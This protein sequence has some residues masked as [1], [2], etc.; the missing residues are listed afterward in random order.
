MI[1]TPFFADGID[2]PLVAL[3]GIAVLVPLMAFQVAVEGGIVCRIWRIPFRDLVR[4]VLLANGWSLI[5]GIPTKFLNGAIYAYILPNDLAGYFARYPFAVTLGALAYF[6]VTVLVEAINLSRWLKRERHTRT[7]S[8]IWIGVLAANIASYAVLAPLHYFATRPI[9]DVKE[10][11]SDTRWA[12]QPPTQIV[13]IDSETGH[14]KSIYSDGSRLTPLVPTEVKDFLV[15]SN[16]DLVLF[17]DQQGIRRLYRTDAKKVEDDNDDQVRPLTTQMT[18]GSEGKDKWGGNDSFKD[19]RAWAEPGLG[20]QIRVYRTNDRQSSLVR[21]VV[22]PGLL[23]NSDFRFR[24]SHP[25]FISDGR[26]C[27]FQDLNAIYLLDIENRRVGK[28]AKGRNF[29]L[30]T[31]AYAKSP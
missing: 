14:L 6:I 31:P 12:R 24:L 18:F 28:I 5:A 19:W 13:Y 25:A 17:H 8:N 9:H 10:F 2:L 23:H 26:E 29:I 3:F 1:P 21:V 27:V 4:P 16:L 7:R 15:T 11:T 30:F 20:N 22:N